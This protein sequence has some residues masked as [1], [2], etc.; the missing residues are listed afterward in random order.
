MNG[1]PPAQPGDIY[2]TQRPSLVSKVPVNRISTQYAI[3]L[4]HKKYLFYFMVLC[5]M[6]NFRTSYI[7]IDN[8][9]FTVSPGERIISMNELMKP[10]HHV[11]RT[12]AF[13]FPF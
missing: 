12:M 9:S 4:Y 3:K 7:L 6:A 11:R 2:R 10:R 5:S 13:S 1:K 8:K